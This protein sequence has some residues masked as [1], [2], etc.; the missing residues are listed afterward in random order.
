MKVFVS[1]KKG[2]TSD[3]FNW[4]DDGELL[5]PVHECN[6]DDCG[7]V[8]SLVGVETRKGTTIFE[9]QEVEISEEDYYIYIAEHMVKSGFNK[10]YA[11]SFALHKGKELLNIASGFIPGTILRRLG[12][13]YY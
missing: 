4:T 13:D 9:V 12:R 5:S 7:C 6:S 11:T 8:H 10:Q 3:D 2:M 1:T